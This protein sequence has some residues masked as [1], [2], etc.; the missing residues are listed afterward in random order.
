MNRRF[1]VPAAIIG[2][3]SMIIAADFRLRADGRIKPD[4]STGLALVRIDPGWSTRRIARAVFP[5]SSDRV[6]FEFYVRLTGSA[7]R[8]QAGEYEFGGGDSIRSVVAKLES[9]RVKR[10]KF[11]IPEGAWARDIFAELEQRE[12]GSAR[13]YTRL[14][15]DPEFV[16]RV[17]G[18]DAPSL[19]GYLYPE[20]HYLV[21]GMDER[22]V[23]TLFVRRFFKTIDPLYQDR[24]DLSGRTLHELVTLA[25]LVERESMVAAERPRIA[26]VFLN[27]LRR[28]MPLESCVTV[29]YALGEKKKRLNSNDLKIASPYN[30]YQHAGL[31]PGPVC[32]PRWASIQAVLDAAP[33]QELY[34]VA[35]GDGTH[36]FSSNHRD[37]ARARRQYLGR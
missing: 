19:E 37:H 33:S 31:P 2:F 36:F 7:P 20:T 23:L 24:I 10:Y 4:P 12:F 22:H 17:L 18:F 11:T 5:A 16:R 9:G 14:F 8:L 29:E 15:S 6:L 32:N 1:A 21:R 30:T 28:R 25:S 27:R 34:F 26:A 35:K 3:I 13:E